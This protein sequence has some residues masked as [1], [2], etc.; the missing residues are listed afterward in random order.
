MESKQHSPERETPASSPS[1]SRREA[2]PALE[3]RETDGRSANSSARSRGDSIDEVVCSRCSSRNSG[4]AQRKSGSH[5]SRQSSEG[6]E[7]VDN[8]AAYTPPPLSSPS[9]AS[10]LTFSHT[11]HS[12]SPLRRELS[13]TTLPEGIDAVTSRAS[14]QGLARR[15]SILARRLTYDDTDGLD[16]GVVGSQL[17]QLEKV[18]GAPTVPEPHKFQQTTTKESP[19]PSER[20]SVLG[21]PVSSL[22]K[23]RFSDLSAS[24][25]RERE[26]E[27]SRNRQDEP[28]PKKGMTIPQAKKVVQEMSKLND[29]LSTLVKNLQARQ[30]ESEVS[31]RGKVL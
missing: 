23:S 24:V 15:L 18:V 3:R 4:S 25:H 22:F 29:E 10:S 17:A 12:I 21:S 8:D 19:S 26:A 2:S 31:D 14:R 6:R 16:E 5:H 7:A 1:W 13:P 20:N 30:E 11:G 28:P 9:M 27:A